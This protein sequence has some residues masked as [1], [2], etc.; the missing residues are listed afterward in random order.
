M[1]VHISD[2]IKPFT[3]H[4]TIGEG[5]IDFEEMIEIF[6]TVNIEFP[7]LLEMMK[8][9]SKYKD[10]DEFLNEAYMGGIA[11]IEKIKDGA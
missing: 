7:L 11:L 9:H 1:A 2:R 3:D 6:K 4:V 8:T 5:F 10:T